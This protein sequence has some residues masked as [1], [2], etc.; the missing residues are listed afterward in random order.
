M[1]DLKITIPPINADTMPSLSAERDDHDEDMPVIKK[2]D[3]TTNLIK[4]FNLASSSVTRGNAMHICKPSTTQTQHTLDKPMKST[5]ML[6]G[7]AKSAKQVTEMDCVKN[8]LLPPNH[9]PARGRG[10]QLQ[11]AKMTAAQKKAEA[12]FRL[13]KNRQ[14][15]RDFRL[16]RKNQVQTLEEQVKK[17]EERDQAQ[18]TQIAHLQAEVARLQA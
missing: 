9:K 2:E 5:K 13:E 11:L 10:R 6:R 4:P 8:K 14:A 1:G 3:N 15:A 17:Y 18:R 16:R 7:K 12:E